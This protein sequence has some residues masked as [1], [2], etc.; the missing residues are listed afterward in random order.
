[1]SAHVAE[2][3]AQYREREATT[4]LARRYGNYTRSQL[5]E[6]VR[7]QKR[8][9][10]RQRPLLARLRAARPRIRAAGRRPGQLSGDTPHDETDE[11]LTACGRGI[12]G[13]VGS[14]GRPAP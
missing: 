4:H 7:E 11:L 6:V 5:A 13:G 2:K 8:G 1:M 14:G 3:I 12:V 9:R 10:S